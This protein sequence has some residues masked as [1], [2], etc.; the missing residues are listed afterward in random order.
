MRKQGLLTCIW[1]CILGVAP[2]AAQS[3]DGYWTS[4]GYGLLIEI[5]GEQMKAYET[6][7]IS[8]LRTWSAQRH[9][10]LSLEG[11]KVFQAGS[12]VI[13]LRPGPL[14]STIRMRQDGI[15][16][17]VVLRHSSQLPSICAR[18]PSNTP[19]VSYAIFWRTFSENYP[20]FSL[21]GVDW[22]AVDARFRPQVR[23]T[24]KP[25]E[26]FEIFRQM[27]EPLHDA[28]TGIE[29]GDLGQHF[30]GSRPDSN[31]LS[32][33]QWEQA[34][35]IIKANYVSDLS[36]FC[37]GHL[38]AGTLNNGIGYLRVDG[39]YGYAEDES[40][41]GS[42][43]ALQSALDSIFQKSGSLRGLVID[44]RKNNGGDDPLGIEIA[45]RLTG[46][47]YLGYKKIARNNKTGPLHFTAPQEVWVTPAAGPGFRGKVVLLT[48]PDTVSAGETFAMA[49]MGRE[50]HVTRIG[51]NTQGV[52]SDTLNRRL[53]NGW[54]FRLPNEV[55]LTAGGEAFDGA[56]IPPEIRV[57]YFSAEDLKRRRDAAIERA[58]AHL[59]S[60]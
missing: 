58:I 28:H 43:R 18:A 4:D 12:R 6:T 34:A 23:P 47:S 17:D 39:F 22:H 30:D 60:G 20:F 51:Q 15:A 33:S 16:S 48:G 52:F 5:R 13:R 25:E 11:E 57:P 50:P 26:L 53:P 19:G 7:S 40:F 31:H 14:P 29:A 37:R 21:H 56:G 41:L 38:Q 10:T 2:L 49:L 1:L 24:T 45:S 59:I 32:A 46:T 8:C 27:L 42:L 9:A 55:Y 3:L 54:R 36:S 35:T 44:V